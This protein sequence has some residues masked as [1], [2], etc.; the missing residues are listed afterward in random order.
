MCGPY[1]IGLEGLVRRACDGFT[2]FGLIEICPIKEWVD[3]GIAMIFKTII[4]CLSGKLSVTSFAVGGMSDGCRTCL[5]SILGNSRC[6]LKTNSEL[7]QYSQQSKQKEHPLSIVLTC[8]VM[9]QYGN[10]TGGFVPGNG[11]F[12]FP[13]ITSTKSISVAP[14]P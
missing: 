1:S 8:S 12:E 11:P 13:V 3:G 5:R 14:R 9:S 7:K 2:R 4:P 6:N 10:E